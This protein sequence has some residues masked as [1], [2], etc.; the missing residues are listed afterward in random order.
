LPD[1]RVPRDHQLST[2]NKKAVRLQT[3][4]KEATIKRYTTHQP[5]KKKKDGLPNCKQSKEKQ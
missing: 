1:A 5:E 2:N 3:K 4:Q